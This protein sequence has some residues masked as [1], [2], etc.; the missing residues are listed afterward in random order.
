MQSLYQRANL[1]GNRIE[2]PPAPL[3]DSTVVYDHILGL[4]SLARALDPSLPATFRFVRY[5]PLDESER[6]EASFKVMFT[7]DKKPLSQGGYRDANAKELWEVLG[8]LMPKDMVEA[9]QKNLASSPRFRFASAVDAAIYDA[10]I[11]QTLT[12]EHK[13]ISDDKIIQVS[14]A[15][16]PP[17]MA[18]LNTPTL[19]RWVYLAPG[20]RAE[21]AL[22]I[23]TDLALWRSDVGHLRRI[24]A[25]DFTEAGGEDLARVKQSV[26]RLAGRRMGS[27]ELD[28]NHGWIGYSL[29]QG[30]KGWTS[31]LLKAGASPFANYQSVSPICW[32]IANDEAKPVKDLIAAG[33]TASSLLLSAPKVF[34]GD[35]QREL[36][37][38]F[39]NVSQLLSF[40]AACG[41]TRS[42]GALLDNGADPNQTGANGA[43]AL[44]IAA[45]AG[46]E[47]SVRLLIG[48]GVDMEIEDSKRNIASQYVPDES[49]SLFDMMETLRLGKEKPQNQPASFRAPGILEKRDSGSTDTYGEQNSLWEETVA[50]PRKIR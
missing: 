25:S 14:E 34:K 15:V 43:T 6:N 28:H 24:L 35:E 4:V 8:E 39:D 27:F 13:V 19:A 37:A 44:H 41:A 23:S 46:D 2:P 20:N 50:P 18:F 7:N 10:F 40:A 11:K 47:R 31:F 5:A 29:A 42:M 1:D 21:N 32:A 17:E 26:Q 48:R 12:L 22:P 45:A 49:D 38:R 36:D 30:A 9:E 3:P 33:A 16:R